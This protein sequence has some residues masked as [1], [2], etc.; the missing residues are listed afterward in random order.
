MCNCCPRIQVLTP[1]GR[2]REAVGFL[3]AMALVILGAFLAARSSGCKAGGLP[4]D[5]PALIRSGTAIAISGGLA[6]LDA[7]HPDGA[8]Q[9]RDAAAR[10][11]AALDA[12]LIPMI[13]GAPTDAV[14]RSTID[15]ALRQLAGLLPA[16][17]APFVR[18]G[19]DLV[20]SH[21]A[22]PGNPAAKLS[23]EARACVSAFLRGASDGL[24]AYLGGRAVRASGVPRGMK[25]LTWER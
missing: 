5:A 19:I 21:V 20:L 3:V 18:I 6:W 24:Q 2:R 16:Q 12:T 23:P 8:A 1:N 4:A 14:L 10:A 11:K 17:A 22:L 25:P 9:T 13:D 7:S 15:E